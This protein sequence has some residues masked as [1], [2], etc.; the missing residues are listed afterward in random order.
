MKCM[1]RQTGYLYEIPLLAI[2]AAIVF[3]ILYPRLGEPWN[4]LFMAALALVVLL[5][6]G[7]N[8]FAAGWQP[9]R[10]HHRDDDEPPS[11]SR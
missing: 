9:G 4:Y 5:F 2:A 10:G 7:Y 11:L 1:H 6:V 8:R 3:G